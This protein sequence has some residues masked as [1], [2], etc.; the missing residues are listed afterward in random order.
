MVQSGQVTVATTPTLIVAASRGGTLLL[1]HRGTAV[2]IGIGRS[3]VGLSGVNEIQ[4]V[5][6]GDATAGDY[7]LRVTDLGGLVF[8]TTVA[9]AQGVAGSVVKTALDAITGVTVTVTGTGTVA[10]PYVITFTEPAETDL[11]LMTIEED[12]TTGGAGAAVAANTDGVS[13]GWIIAQNDVV[14]PFPVAQGVSIYGIVAAS[15]EPVH[16]LLVE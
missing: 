11:P 6:D 7:K 10:D 1:A 8:G 3:D 9:I 5:D 4:D 2:D 16:F 14:P 12:T 13:A 15:T